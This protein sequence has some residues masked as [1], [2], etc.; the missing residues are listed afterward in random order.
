MLAI[1]KVCLSNQENDFINNV[2]SAPLL[3]TA[4]CSVRLGFNF[5]LQ[6]LGK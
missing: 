5:P 2:L 3:S 6:Q 1:D 4:V